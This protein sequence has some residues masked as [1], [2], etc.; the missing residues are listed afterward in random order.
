MGD[1]TTAFVGPEAVQ[2]GPDPPPRCLDGAFGGAPEERFELG[3]ALFNRVE[4]GG[5]GRQEAQR[6]PRSLNGPPHSRA[7]VAAESVQDDDIAGRERR[8]QAVFHIGQEAGAVERAVED[9]GGG[10][11]VVAE[12]GHERQGLPVAR[13][14]RGA[15]ARALR[16]A[17]VAAGPSRLGPRLINKHKVGGI[18]AALQTLPTRPAPRDGG[19]LL[20]GGRSAFF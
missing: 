6:G 4:I 13:Q 14:P 1:V 16:A 10:N 2:E 18:K 15:Q 11:T 8:E 5:G 7:R 3:E 20:L 12:G 9:T 19:P 17:T